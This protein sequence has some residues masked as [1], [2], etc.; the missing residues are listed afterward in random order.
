[1]YFAVALTTWSIL[2]TLAEFGLGT[3][4]VRARD[5]SGRAPTVASVGLITSGLLALGMAIAA[6]PIAQPSTVPSR[7]RLFGSWRSACYLRLL[8][9]ARRLPP[10]TPPGHSPRRP[11][12]AGRRGLSWSRARRPS[13]P[14]AISSAT[15]GPGWRRSPG[16]PC[17]PSAAALGVTGRRGTT[18]WGRGARRRSPRN[19]EAGS[20]RR[21]GNHEVEENECRGNG[22]AGDPTR[23]RPGQAQHVPR[24]RPTSASRSTAPTGR[25]S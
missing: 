20:R 19:R 5:F 6:G 14:T 16:P 2:G 23:G 17:G 24:Q 25:W 18:A 15:A 12:G 21:P 4:L 11:R 3:D 10:V 13:L 1:M 9:R 7:R 22:G 8:H